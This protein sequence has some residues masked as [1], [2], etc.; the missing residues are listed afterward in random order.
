MGGGRKG[1]R[2]GGGIE[3]GREGG[4]GE[5]EREWSEG[6]GL[7]SIIECEY[8]EIRIQTSVIGENREP[9]L[10]FRANISTLFHSFLR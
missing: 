1:G 10:S 5:G 9:T 4:R 6:K 2:E 7:G 3:G 8:G